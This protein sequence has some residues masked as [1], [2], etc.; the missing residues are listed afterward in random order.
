MPYRSH[1]VPA[2]SGGVGPVGGVSSFGYSGTIAHALLQGASG[3]ATLAV[4]GGAA[5][6]RFRRRAFSWASAAAE[7]LDAS[8][9]ALYSVD[10][11]ELAVPTASSP[12]GE[13]LVVQ[14][15]GA[16]GVAARAIR[17]R[18]LLRACGQ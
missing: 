13:W 18:P 17:A 3:G 7:A 8:A 15:A 16:L 1:Q 11:A 2:G 14:P 10:W 5:S 6:L 12:G 4:G 9:I